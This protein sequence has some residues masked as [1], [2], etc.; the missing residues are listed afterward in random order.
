[1][2]R[3]LCQELTQCVGEAVLLQGW[4]HR[5]RRL[6]GLVFLQVRDRSGIV[7]VALEG[8]LAAIPLSHEDVVQVTGQVAAEPRAPGGVEVRAN[9][10]AVLGRAAELPFEVNGREMKA[11]LDVQLDH[12]VLSLR[13]AK[14]H[15]ALQVQA[16][17]IQG[18][19]HYLLGQGFTEIHTP[20]LVATGT[21]GGSE[22]FA[23]QYFERQVYLAQ[24]PQFYK[25]MMVGAGYERVFE[26]GPV[27]RAEEHN[28]S[29][30][31]NEYVSLD[32]EMG[33]IQN[34]E[35][36][37]ALETGLLQSV[38]SRVRERLPEALALHQAEAPEVTE[39]PRL[40]LAEAQAILRRHYRKESPEGNLDPEGERLICEHVGGNQLVF[41][42]RYPVSKRPMYAMPA[43]DA[44]ELTA[45]FDLLFRGLEV[46][47]GGQ[48]HHEYER[49]VASIKSRG[50]AP[51]DFASYL[52]VFRLGMPP[53]GGFAIGAER[54]TA[55]LLG[56]NNVRE[57][58]AF[59][60]DRTRVQP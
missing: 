30:H 59:P 21:E 6:G 40:P 46:T 34:E 22:V 42:T 44:P 39:I 41:V 49:L 3:S 43:A 23:V 28:T 35:D 29:R 8:E 20:K 26:V 58:A 60:R 37:M 38:F 7:Q 57:A 45:S 54:L 13:H 32:V 53:H 17:V 55:R 2:N 10:L 31:L 36:L 50:L 24:S 16:A 18:F 52:E 5:V 47:T 19:R 4:A 56:L 48:R 12:R 9:S 25:Q 33:F 15:A 11:G 27:F 51:Q 1:M 14:A